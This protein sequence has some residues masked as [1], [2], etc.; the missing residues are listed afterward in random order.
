MISL[1]C[2]G[3]GFE[4]PLTEGMPPFVCPKHSDGGFHVLRPYLPLPSVGGTPAFAHPFLRFA[5]RMLAYHRCREYGLA[6]AELY[7]STVEKLT[8]QVTHLTGKSF[9]HTPLYR[10]DALS[11]WFGL[12]ERGGVY[13]KDETQNPGGSHKGRH[14]FGIMVELLVGEALSLAGSGTHRPP[15]AIASC[16]NAALA[17]AVVAKA[18]HWPLQVFIPD[19]AEASVVSSL[20]ELGATITVCSRSAGETGDPCYRRFVEAVKSGAIPFCCQGPDNG[21]TLDGGQTLMAEALSDMVSLE[22]I[23][24]RI[25][26]QVGGGALAASC[27]LAVETAL[28]TGLLSHRPRFFTVQ[29]ESVSPLSRA[30]AKLRAEYGPQ[31]R[32]LSDAEW[33]QIAAHKTKYMWPWESVPHSAAHGIL[34]DETY[35]WLPCVKEIWKSNGDALTV[36]ESAILAAHDLAKRTTGIAVSAT[37]S[38]GLAGLLTEHKH[39]PLHPDE[40]VLILLTGVAR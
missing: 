40:N 30:L 13:V 20:R 25:F 5:D 11:D 16:G 27:A 37:G 34:D 1:R 26:V 7:H 2:A 38:A 8:E 10:S 29:T 35:D 17:A 32:I 14:L 12:S 4:V 36:P 33:R 24:A 39:S 18:A 19:D 15:L 31:G 9:S 6:H 3:C 23:P 21:L 22:T 28:C